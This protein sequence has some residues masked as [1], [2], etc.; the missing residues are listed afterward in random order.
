MNYTVYMEMYKLLIRMNSLFKAPV[1]PFNLN[2]DGVMTYSEWQ[3]NKGEETIKYFLSVAKKEEI[4]N[5]KL[6]LD[7]GCGA[8]GKTVYYASLGAKKVTGLE[9]LEKYRDE[10]VNLAEKKGYAD[11]FE[12]LCADAANTG[13]GDSSVDTIIINDAMEHVDNPEG[14]LRESLRILKQGG[15]LYIN[16]PPYFHPFGAHLSDAI[17]IPWVHLLFK[18]QTLMEA[19]KRLTAGLPDGEERVN[20]RMSKDSEGRERLS[21]INKM[22]IKKFKNI[23]K[24]ITAKRVYYFEAPLRRFFSIPARIPFIKEMF[25]KMVV[26]V[27]EK[28]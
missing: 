11:K 12:F 19:Y 27:L 14:V 2:N 5:G 17:Y 9:I 3:F 16:F 18:E 23:L 13:F 7:V 21:Y 10:A 25:V 4:F 15:R 1:H 22:T 8:A 20:F 28:G 24:R 26:C 6:V